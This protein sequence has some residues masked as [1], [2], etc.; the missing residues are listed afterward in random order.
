M[1]NHPKIEA[2]M[3]AGK[4]LPPPP[5]FKQKLVRRFA[6]AFALDTLVETG[7]GS[8]E[9]IEATKDLFH[10]IYSIEL[11]PLLFDQAR[12]RFSALKHITV[13][14]GDSGLRLPDILKNINEPSLF[15]L[16]AHYAW[17]DS[18]PEKKDTPIREELFHILSHEFRHV[19]L[20]DDA[21][22]F[23]GRRGYPTLEELRSVIANRWDAVQFIVKD[24][25]IRIY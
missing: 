5:I 12:L 3:R 6:A 9:M 16:D 13:I 15:W 14:E 24:D 23:T 11:H 2:W 22:Y 4:P 18:T 20:I 17:R 10:H 21:R 8:G 7:T 25:I 1:T 19:I